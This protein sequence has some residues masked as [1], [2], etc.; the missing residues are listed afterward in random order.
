MSYDHRS[1]EKKW[2]EYWERAG[3]FAVE[4]DSNRSKY[5]V[6]DMF[7]YP[8]GEGLH[9]GHI[10]G[11]TASDIIARYKR[12]CGNNVLHPMGWDSFGLPAEQYALRTGQHPAKTT[13]RNIARYRQQLKAMGFS[14]DWSR[15]F[16]TSDH[17]YYRWTQWMFS[18]LFERGLAYQ[19]D[20]LVNYCPHLS[21]V[22]ANEEVE[23]GRSKEGGYE[24]VRRPLRQWLLKITAYA[25]RL[26]EDLKE[27]EWPEALKRQ[28]R[29][30]IGKSQGVEIAFWQSQSCQS[31]YVFTTR[32]DTLMGVTFL[33]L[34]PEHPLFA[35]VPDSHRVSIVEYRKRAS[36]LSDLQRTDGAKE[37]TGVFSGLFAQHPLSGEDIPLFAA[38]YV[39]GSYGTGA[40]M[41]V[42]AHDERDFALAQKLELPV[43][44][45]VIPDG[46]EGAQFALDDLKKGRI[47]FAKK[48]ILFKSNCPEIADL[49]HLDGVQSDQGS[50]KISAYLT[51]VGKGGA[52]TSYKLRD[53]LFSRQRYWGEPIPILHF[54]DGSKRCLQLDE[55]PLCP[56]HVEDFKPDPQGQS[57]LARVRSW[58]EIE[59]GKTEKRATRETNTMPQWAGSCWYYLR[60]C[61]P[62]ND[63]A[64]VDPAKERYWMP[65]DSYVGGAEHAVLHLLYARFWHKVLFDCDL[66]STKEPF[67]QLKNPGMITSRSY[68][69]ESGSYLSPT[70]VHH[71]PEGRALCAKTKE[72]LIVQEEKMSKSKLNGVNPDELL[73]RFGA[74]ALRV[75]EMFMGPLDREKIWN[76]DAIVG[77]CRFLQRADLLARN[78]R[79]SRSGNG[80]QARFLT[81]Q[82][83]SDVQSDY[84]LW[85]FNTLIAKLMKYLNE[86]EPLE[87]YPIDCIEIFVK[88]FAPLAPHLAE[89]L[90]EHLGHSPSIAN[91]PFPSCDQA[92]LKRSRS[93]EITYIIQVDGKLRARLQLPRGMKS[94]QLLALARKLP[95]VAKFIEGAR[96][97]KII[98]VPDKLLNIAVKK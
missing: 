36:R 64:F 98:F 73:E 59:D 2:Q 49:A 6:L 15:E 95:S 61:D 50:D 42:P 74:D 70:D 71:L 7:P 39:L 87:S 90:W 80:D 62:H 65:V 1:V 52:K 14:Y 45:A 81:H 63:E 47:C 57:P 41:G 54:A 83:I 76:T 28:Q 8:S 86:I 11:Y 93:Q 89:E 72:P 29:N 12:M 31:I 26:L 69:L 20:V 85:Q 48:G 35:S 46:D 66:V 23:E 68:R 13:E 34:A 5:Y 10:L 96:S 56:P 58:V 67:R 91:A 92:L 21:A 22:L 44:C 16:A 37:Q 88:L 60:F 51:N 82:L 32:A 4:P 79:V 33:A 53:W 97:E 9:V 55:L 43:R 84:E 77:S 38:D 3:T 30:W 25:E 17:R 18:L 27:L 94:Q 19:A 75:Y 40:V 78:D 24:V